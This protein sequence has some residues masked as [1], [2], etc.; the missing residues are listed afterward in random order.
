MGVKL[1]K[2]IVG[3]ALDKDE[4][5]GQAVAIDASNTLMTFINQKYYSRYTKTYTRPLDKTQRIISH[6]YGVFYRTIRL[7]EHR[8]M[9]IYCFDGIP[10]DRK[11]LTTKNIYNDF[12][13]T[14]KR[15]VNALDSGNRTKARSI[16]LGKEFLWRNCIREARDLLRGMGIP[17]I[18]SP[19]EGEAQ[20]SQLVKMG[21]CD[22]T[23][24]EDF[25][26]ILYGSNKM[27]QLNKLTQRK[28]EANV[29]AQDDVCKQL[30]LTRYQ[31][32]DLSIIIGND[33]FNG[34]PSIGIK[35][36][37]KLLRKYGSL[38]RIVKR[39]LIETKNINILSYISLDEINQ[40]RKLFLMPE[41]MNK[42]PVLE[43]RYPTTGTIIDLLCSDHNLSPK[44]VQNGIKRL[45]KAYKKLNNVQ[46]R[47][48]QMKLRIK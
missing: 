17:F 48:K 41:V 25:D 26:V 12:E 34:I 36:G 39:N 27:I 46:N 4:L 35:T 15:Y 6:L 2:E 18:N 3:R 10:D 44:R 5:K 13:M 1:G 30:K 42:L 47:G 8:I 9:P 31:L 37:I 38:N 33:Y 21:V 43:L 24:S 29:Y 7:L 22:A 11:R 14:K 20:C 40:I 23:I 45:I 16:A 28:I 32:I 19:T